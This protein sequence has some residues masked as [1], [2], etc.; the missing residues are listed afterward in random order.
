MR[1]FDFPNLFMRV[2][3]LVI[4]GLLLTYAGFAFLGLQAVEQSTARTLEERM[5]IAQLAASRVDDLLHQK[6]T[7][8]QAMISDGSVDPKT[9]QS[10]ATRAG[11]Q[12]MHRYLGD[13]VNYVAVLDDTGK[14]IST[15][16]R[17]PA[18]VGQPLAGNRFVARVLKSGEPVVSGYFAPSGV[19]PSAAILVPAMRPGEA[20]RGLVLAAVNLKHSSIS[21]LLGSSGIGERGYVEI[22][23]EEGFPLASTS[24]D[25]SWQNCRY[26]DRFY[27]LIRDRGAMVGRC[28]DCH[29]DAVN[30]HRQNGVMAFAAL[31]VAPW[32]VVVQQRE[33]EAFAY[34]HSLQQNLLLFGGAAFLVTLVVAW[35]LTRGVVV[36]IRSL[37]RATQQ[38]AAGDLSQP[39]SRTGGAEVGVLA[40]SF[41]DMRQRLARSLD[42][43][44]GWNQE[45]ERRVE[46]RT[47]ELKEAEQVRR[48]LLRKI[49]VT[50]E[51]ERKA[52]A[53]ELHDETSQALTALVVRLETIAADPAQ[54]SE[55]IRAE[56]ES[57][58]KQAA[59]MLR[60]IQ[61]IILDL[62]PAILDDL[63]L[64]EAIDW[65]AETRLGPQGV[66]PS[67]ET[68]GAERRL[69]SEIEA[70]LFR[71]AQEMINNVA[72]HA[73]AENVAISLNFDESTV[74]LELEDDGCGFSSEQ[75]MSRR[76]G[77]TSFGLLGMRERVRL[78]GGSLQVESTVGQGARIVAT[79]PLNGVPSNGKDSHHPG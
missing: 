47:Q 41:D 10:E 20:G 17:M 72:R 13:F 38:I 43:I 25:E 19:D 45:L 54:N 67:L 42:E 4:V 5:L 49:V 23:D 28:H 21:H 44:R 71:I 6:I 63:G 12:V 9:T 66:R 53:R 52:L 64:V 56:L 60:E 78:F 30:A 33:Q 75:A 59:I 73:R 34:S 40:R 65:Y 68:V 16:P 27:S 22:I 24:E 18:L 77:G 76:N 79:L 55:E 15:E 37:T 32:G 7:V 50:Q 57:V 2:I 8:I 36:P 39:I 26:G 11:L 51:E 31:S 58:K 48:E 69:P 3:L 74:V 46:E 14:V 62:R 70:V 29:S 61:R 1:I 35:L